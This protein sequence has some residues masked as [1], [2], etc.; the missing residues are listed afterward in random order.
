M[1]NVDISEGYRIFKAEYERVCT[2]FIPIRRESNGIKR[3]AWMSDELREKLRSKHRAWHR[4]RS[5]A[6]RVV[7]RKESKKLK[8]AI[9]S[10]KLQFEKELG[11]RA[12]KDPKLIHC[13]IRNKLEVKEQK[14][15]NNGLAKALAHSRRI[16]GWIPSIPIDLCSFSDFSLLSISPKLRLSSIFCTSIETFVLVLKSG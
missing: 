13:Y 8:K 9:K 16:L 4:I 12:K 10:A 14:R 11:E 3:D 5:K 1:K 2:K 6:D 15:V 7:F